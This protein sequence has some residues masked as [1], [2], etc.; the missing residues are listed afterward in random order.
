MILLDITDGIDDKIIN[1]NDFSDEKSINL[2]FVN[3]YENYNIIDFFDENITNFTK[4]ETKYLKC[5]ICEFIGSG[6]YGKVYKIKINK[7]FYALKISENEKPLNLKLRY[8]SLL[9]IEQFKRYVIQFYVCGNINCNKYKYFSIMEY[10]GN[11]L[12]SM[13]PF[14]STEEIKFIMKQLYN[15]VYLCTVFR[16]YLTDF[17][18][19]NIVINNNDMRLKLIDIYMEC[20]SYNP[21]KECRIVKT[22]S[23]LE[24][25]KIKNILDD[26]DYNHTYHLIPLA[27]G[28]IDLLCKKNFSSIISSLSHKFNINLNLKQ[29]IP[30]IQV[31]TYNYEHKSNNLIKKYHNVYRT[32]K[33]I[34]KKYPI[35]IDNIFY[36]TF[37]NMINV[38][39]TYENIISS[40]K[41]QNIIYHL[42]S[43]YPEDRTLEPLKKFLNN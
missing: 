25:D 39:N 24:M 20:K 28:L 38:R 10:G 4:G 23:T 18:F 26:T 3:D 5:K 1:S 42:F 22:Y 8:E 2:K 37:I 43:V 17:K 19:N 40:K 21:C 13:I 29:I 12:K 33:K 32:K 35:I 7:K 11:S 15:I 27:I 6:S 16:L 14:N 9:N 34:E 31:A 36:I 30:L 41:L